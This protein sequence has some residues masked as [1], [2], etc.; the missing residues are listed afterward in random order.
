MTSGC[1]GHAAASPQ[2]IDVDVAGDHLAVDA[3]LDDAEAVTP[4][5]PAVAPHLVVEHEPPVDCG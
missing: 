5:A 2:I 3:V 1:G 4:V